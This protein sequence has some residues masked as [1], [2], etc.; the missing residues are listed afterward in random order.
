VATYIV[1]NAKNVAQ[2]NDGVCWWAGAM[3][4]YQWSQASNGNMKEPN[5]DDDVKQRWENNRDWPA[6]NSTQLAT[7]LRLKT[8]TDVPKDYDGLK[9]FLQVH[10]PVWTAL[11]KNWGGND[12]SHVVVIAGVRD[13]GVLAFDPEP[14]GA[15]SRKWL[16]WDQFQTALD[17]LGAAVPYLT[18]K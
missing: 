11:Q 15:G 9:D 14:V 1:P 6:C 17:G 3:V 2:M 5:A 7:K 4:L 16:T 18:V 8:Y 13:D 10:G 12:Y